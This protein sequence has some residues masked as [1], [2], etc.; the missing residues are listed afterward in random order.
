LFSN[1]EKEPANDEDWLHKP[2]NMEE[3]LN[4]LKT[5]RTNLLFATS[6]VEEGVD[7]SSCSFVIAF[8]NIKTTK[9]Y[10]Q[11]KGRARYVGSHYI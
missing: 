7:I 11:M 9:I 8:D 4:G 1:K 2:T 6:V 5:K 10:V 3:I